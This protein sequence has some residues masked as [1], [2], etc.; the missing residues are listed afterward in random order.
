MGHAMEWMSGGFTGFRLAPWPWIGIALLLLLFSYGLGYIPGGSLAVVLLGP[1]I[2]GGIMLGCRALDEGQPLEVSHFFAGFQHR[3][4]TLVKAGALYVALILGV[5]IVVGLLGALLGVELPDTP[6]E[7]QEVPVV[8]TL[9]AILVLLAFAAIIPIAMA[10]YYAPAL[11]VF[12][13]ELG[14]GDAYRLSFQGCLRNILPFLLYGLLGVLLGLFVLVTL[15]LGMLI[16]VPILYAG[17]YV[18]YK[19]IFLGEDP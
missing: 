2:T 18:S 10:F 9:L 11:L 8:N 7:G 5:F 17:T 12:H 16:V 4:G 19:D 6:V 15:G 1:V 13:E 3:T 14:V